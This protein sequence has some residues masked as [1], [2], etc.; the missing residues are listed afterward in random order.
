M[1][2]KSSQLVRAS[3]MEEGPSYNVKEI[4]NTSNGA[5]SSRGTT[6]PKLSA[7]CTRCS[8]LVSEADSD[9]V[10]LIK[11]KCSDT[12][13]RLVHDGC[14]DEW[15]RLRGDRCSFCQEQI[16]YK[17][18]KISSDSTQTTGGSSQRPKVSKWK[19]FWCGWHDS[20]DFK[21]QS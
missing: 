6:I 13:D 10:L 3:T 9:H 20:D 4:D 2:Y 19:R 1:T 17:K 18:V 12:S 21:V 16:L 11:C 7:V 14:K 8:K 15:S 5:Q